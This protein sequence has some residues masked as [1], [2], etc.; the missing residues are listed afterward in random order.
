MGGGAGAQAG[1]AKMIAFEQ[2]MRARFASGRPLRFV[3]DGANVAY[4][5]QNF[6][7][8]SF[9]YSQIDVMLERLIKD[10]GCSYEEILLLVPEKYLQ[11]VVPNHVRK[12]RVRFCPH[13]AMHEA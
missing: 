11:D 1:H 7:G 9:A 2:A 8:G 6:H 13:M 5:H 12:N 10:Y 4:C 3:V